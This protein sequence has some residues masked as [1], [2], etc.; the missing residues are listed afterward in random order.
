MKKILPIIVLFLFTFSGYLAAQSITLADDGDIIEGAEN[1]EEITVTLSDDTFEATID[2]GNIS[3][4]N[5]P[6]GVT[7]SITRDSDTQLTITLTHNRTQDYDLAITDLTVSILHNELVTL[8]SGSV[9]ASSG[10]TFT[11]TNDT[12]S[13]SMADDGTIDE[14]SEGGEEITVTLTGGT[15][16]SSLN[17]DNWTLANLPAGV[18]K[19]PVSRENDTEVKIT[20]NNDRDDDYDSNIINLTLTV[21]A[22]E[23]DD[24]TGSA[25]VMNS[26]VTFVANNDVESISMTDDGDITEAH[27]NGEE[28]TVTLT[29]GTFVSPLT[30]ASWALTNLPTGV[31]KGTILEQAQQRLP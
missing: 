7:Y 13:M 3:V 24:T 22:D 26:G 11:A 1:M 30:S 29:G 17:T 23:V 16:V 27:E 4:T 19:G 25:F 18:T 8:S 31:T 5:L 14:G 12:E 10:V 6:G 21:S 20:L 2:D 28:I 15:F 9:D